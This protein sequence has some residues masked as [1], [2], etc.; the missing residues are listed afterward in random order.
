MTAKSTFQHLEV[1][2]SERVATVWLN[3]PEKLNAMSADIW[4]DLPMAIKALDEDPEIRV[5]VIAG[6]GGN[7]T[8]GI[9]VGMLAGLVPAGDSPAATSR[10]I[11][12]KVVELQETASVLAR[13]PKPVIA[14]IEG[15]CLGA[16][17]DLITAC[18]IRICSANAVF[19][20]RETRMG[21]VADI[22]TLQR[23]PGIVGD[24]MAAELALTGADFD[25]ERA[26]EIGLVTGVLPD[27]E[28]LHGEAMRLA[29]AIA[30][31][32]PL[33]LD[34]VK[35][36]LAA[37]RGR[38]VEEALDHVALWNAAHLVSN[39]LFEAMAA[40]TEKRPPNFTGS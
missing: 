5:I 1:E 14:A 13:S 6:R 36:M 8:V 20:I 9:D 17:M 38:T 10:R 12:D 4:A 40:F 32:S 28:T 29:T 26:K 23:L 37:N 35:R 3:R 24:G 15:F 18:D 39:D 2:R 25:A 33:V 27:G 22:G 16:G 31:N 19:S 30:G 21:L 7:F 34:G 11:Y